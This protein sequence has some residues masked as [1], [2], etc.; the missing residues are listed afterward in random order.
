MKEE[1]IEEKK[2]NMKRRELM[3][4]N[5]MFLPDNFNLKEVIN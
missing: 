5:G 1:E 4:R 2:G 3:K